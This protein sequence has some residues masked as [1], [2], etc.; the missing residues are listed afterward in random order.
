MIQGCIDHLQNGISGDNAKLLRLQGQLKKD[1]YRIVVENLKGN[2]EMSWNKIIQSFKPLF[3]QLKNQ[4]KNERFKEVFGGKDAEFK[5]TFREI[6]KKISDGI[7]KDVDIELE[8][9]KKK[10][11]PLFLQT[12]IAQKEF[13]K[14][15]PE[16]VENLKFHKY[17][18]VDL[19]YY[20]RDGMGLESHKK[21]NFLM[22]KIHFGDILYDFDVNEY[23]L[24]ITPPCDA[25]RPQKTDYNY[26]FIRGRKL[27][28]IE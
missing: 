20:L 1:I 26:T 25:F 19:G 16:L 2:Q 11:M 6:Y 8:N 15:F 18:K 27:K 23:L 14:S 24:C 4:R 3:K 17:E 5:I 10:V 12:L 7:S 28:L 9:Y 21:S 22:N 13:L